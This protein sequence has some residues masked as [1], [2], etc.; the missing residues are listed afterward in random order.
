MRKISL[1]ITHYAF[2]IITCASIIL[3]TATVNAAELVILHTNDIHAR[4]LNTDDGGKS[5]GLAEMVAAIKTLKNQN[6]NSLWLD[7]GDTFHGMPTIN[8]SKG[9]NMLNLL[10]IAGLDAMTIGNHDFN[11]GVEPL[12]NLAKKAKFD[13]LDANLVYRSNDKLVFK[14][15][16][17]YKMPDGLRVGVF[18]LTTPETQ[19]KARPALVRGI[20]FLNPVEIA[21]DMVKEL[22]PKCDVLIA[23]THLGINEHSDFT[24]IRVANEVDGIDLIVDGHSHTVLP[25]GLTI[26]KTIIVQTGCHAYNLGKATIMLDDKKI[27]G[28]K[29]ELLDAKAVKK[30]N[31]TPDK[32]ISAAIVKMDRAN[33]KL[34]NQVIAKNDK[35]LSG[36]KNIM[37]T[38]ETELGDLIADAFRWRTGADIAVINSGGIRDDLPA[39]N[40]TKGDV[41]KIFPFG[42][43]LQVVEISGIKIREMLEVSV[44]GYPESFNGFLQISGLRFTFNSD[45]EMLNRVGEIFVNNSPL[46]E[47]KIYT[48]ATSNFI[49]EGGDH[50]DMLKK[51]LI[52]GQFGTLEEV[53]A[54]Y[55]KEIGMKKIDIGR[56]IVAK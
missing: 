28:I 27:T 20:N 14:P 16:K 31:P 9:E 52:I 46:V 54:D 30:I 11:Y 32:N 48:L 38:S 3:F 25:A 53:L 17:I 19:V 1:R 42:N 43:Q 41:M 22:R 24:S 6:K 35:N 45:N 34:F 55:L 37:R 39:G 8:V 44:A 29:A 7:A 49:L 50:Y 2:L 47:D 21:K 56:I 18:G 15:Y 23:L 26:N 12:L 36:N 51:L 4:V 33:R 40:V 13:F 5:M 10:N